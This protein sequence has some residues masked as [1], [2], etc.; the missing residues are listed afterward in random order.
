[1]EKPTRLEVVL[2]LRER[3]T[4]RLVAIESTC[5]KI[6]VDFNLRRSQGGLC[7]ELEFVVAD[8]FP[9]KPEEGL[10]EVV[11]GSGRDLKVLDILLAVEGDGAGFDFALLKTS[12]AV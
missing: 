4:I 9:G 11:V 12:K 1:M 10:L 7:D 3:N 5:N 2:F 6:G 8:Q